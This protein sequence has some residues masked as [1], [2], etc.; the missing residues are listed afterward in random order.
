MHFP[1]C[2]LTGTNPSNSQLELVAFPMILYTRVVAEECFE[3]GRQAYV[4]HDYYHAIMW[5][6]EAYEKVV[7]EKN[8]TAPKTVVLDYLQYSLYKV[9]TDNLH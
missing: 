3:V 8:A 4:G 9:S 5:M 1:A 2:H 6:Q 7:I